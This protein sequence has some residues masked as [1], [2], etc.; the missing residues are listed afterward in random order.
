MK[1]PLLKYAVGIDV[2]K[3]DFHVYL[4]VIDILQ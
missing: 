4:S 1:N 2:S 3:N